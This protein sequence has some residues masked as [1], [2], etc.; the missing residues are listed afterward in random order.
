MKNLFALFFV[1]LINVFM[2]GYI[3]NFKLKIKKFFILIQNFI[4][5][6]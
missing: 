6:E 5:R 4:Y 3:Y 2:V 1:I